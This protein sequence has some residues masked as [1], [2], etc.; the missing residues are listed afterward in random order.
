MEVK[1]TRRGLESL[2]KIAAYIALDSP[3]AASNFVAEIREK[4]AVLAQHPAIGRAGR[5]VVDTRE[6]VVHEN[7]VM[8]YRV[9]ADTVQILR[10]HHVAQQI[11][12]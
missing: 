6:M 11:L 7:Y 12:K 5:L 4:S 3:L 9:K 10:V 1:W 2:D 8:I